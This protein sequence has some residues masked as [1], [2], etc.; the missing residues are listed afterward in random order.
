MVPAG[1]EGLANAFGQSQQPFGQGAG[2][3]HQQIQQQQ[4][5]VRHLTKLLQ[6]RNCSNPSI[7]D[8]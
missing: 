6:L 2:D 3:H 7:P 1:M 5:Q 8:V 4:Q